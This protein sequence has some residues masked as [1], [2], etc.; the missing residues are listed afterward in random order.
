MNRYLPFL[1][2]Y[3]KGISG[4][5]IASIEAAIALEEMSEADTEETIDETTKEATDETM[6]NNTKQLKKVYEKIRKLRTRTR[7]PIE[8]ENKRTDWMR[9][10]DVMQRLDVTKEKRTTKQQQQQQ[11]HKTKQ[12]KITRNK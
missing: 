10:V 1:K 8:R 5:G 2:I 12:P 4:N 3:C 11:L 9:Q 6:D 7:N